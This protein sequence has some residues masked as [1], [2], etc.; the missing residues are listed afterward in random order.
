MEKLRTGKKKE[1]MKV[2]NT[3][4]EKKI[5]SR[6]KMKVGKQYRSERTRERMKARGQHEM[7]KAKLYKAT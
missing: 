5:G 7:K 4:R 1:L 6:R 3:E 2:R